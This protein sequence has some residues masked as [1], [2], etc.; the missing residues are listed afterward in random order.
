MFFS[1]SFKCVELKTI[2]NICTPKKKSND[3]E[4]T[5]K[6]EEIL[7]RYLTFYCNVADLIVKEIQQEKSLLNDP[8]P[9]RQ[10]A[11]YFELFDHVCKNSN[12]E[13]LFLSFYFKRKNKW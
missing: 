2:A 9:Y 1:C 10:G 7:L 13:L 11:V 12:F 4:K 3:T 8:I 6:L 5:S